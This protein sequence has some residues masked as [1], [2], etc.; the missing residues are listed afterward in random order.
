[1]KP[2]IILVDDEVNVLQAYG[3]VLRARFA[4]DTAEGGEAALGMLSERGPYAV[5]VSDMRM[6]GMDGVELLAQ[7]KG[8]FPDTVRIMLTGNADQGTAAEAVNRG[9]IFRF[10]SKPCDSALLIETIHQA[11][12]QHELLTAEKA[13]LEGTLKGSIRMLVD[14]L[15]LLD[16]I[17]F[18]RAQEMGE[19][20]EGVAREMGMENPLS[21]I[22]I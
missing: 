16:P 11:V 14:L 1:M 7:A 6:P 17:S 3:R 8:R 15:S 9:E 20:A 18:G 21:L 22:H 19:L 5:V 4:V 12:R 2:R 10:L 13:L